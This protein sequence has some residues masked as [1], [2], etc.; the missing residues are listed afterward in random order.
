MK[1]LFL[2]VLLSNCFNVFAQDFLGYAHSN[3][4][5]ITGASYNPAS[6]ADSKLSLDIQLFGFGIEAG[7]N[8]VGVKRKDIFRSDF[9]TPY[10]HLR[11][12]NTKKAVFVRNEILLPGVMFSKS[13]YGW[14]IDM[15]VRT[16]LNVDGV[17]RDLAHIFAYELNDPPNFNRQLQNKHL[18][19]TMMS[20]TEIAGTYA[21][22]IRS[23]AEHYLS[24]GVRPKFLLGLASAYIFL[25]D[26]EYNFVNDTSLTLIKGDLRFGHSSNF[27]FDGSMTPSWKLGF[28]P[29]LG[30]D[31]G[32]SYEFR[33]DELQEHS[34]DDKEKPWPGF[35][36]RPKY[37]YRIGAAITDLGFIYF[38]HGEFSDRYTVDANL[39]DLN[40]VLLDS[41]SPT[42][43]Y[44]T[45]EVRS[46]GSKKGKGYIMTLPLALNLQ[47]D[48]M[49]REH[50]YVNATAFT[51]LYLRNSNFKKVHELTRLSITPRWEKRWFGVWM[52]LSF[53]RLGVFAVGSGIRLGPFAIGTTDI[54]ALAL[55][56]KTV[57]SADLYFVLKVPLFPKGGLKT[58]KGKT[59][60]KSKIDDCA[61]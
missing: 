45:F 11:D 8:Y 7:N 34:K 17:S 3:Y 43:I 55:R 2:F 39:W 6:L 35:R 23:G 38:R 53:S 59:K 37:K 41:T 46:G 1:K 48:Y 60:D 33:P 25:N 13:E 51:A 44:N 42:S 29:G 54:L 36:E 58:K 16:Y 14:G 5:G 49:I 28:N 12:I 32:I 56:S 4:A 24:A 20:W 50:L 47:Y 57:Y 15:K 52:P 26:A 27:S 19:V 30:I 18:G 61:K 31:A 10:L 9:G 22:T 40:D 21:K